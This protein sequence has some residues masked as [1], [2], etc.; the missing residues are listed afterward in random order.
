MEVEKFVEGSQLYYLYMCAPT[1]AL[2]L[3]NKAKRKHIRDEFHSIC[4]SLKSNNDV[5]WGTLDISDTILKISSWLKDAERVL[6]D[7]VDPK[8]KLELI[9]KLYATS[10]SKTSTYD[11]GIN[12]MHRECQRGVQTAFSSSTEDS[13]ENNEDSAEDGFGGKYIDTRSRAIKKISNSVETPHVVAAIQSKPDSPASSSRTFDTTSSIRDFLTEIPIDSTLSALLAMTDVADR[14]YH[15][16][17]TRF[18]KNAN[19]VHEELR[20]QELNDAI[21]SDE[22]YNRSQQDLARQLREQHLRE[23]QMEEARL[24]D[25]QAEMDACKQLDNEMAQ[26]NVNKFLE[27]KFGSHNTT[28]RRKIL[29]NYVFQEEVLPKWAITTSPKFY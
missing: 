29:Q 13:I 10:F 21:D 20:L 27:G 16:R 18:N 4:N 6:V 24:K 22:E 17:E 23:K 14:F 15:S 25:L 28:H 2:L 19:R 5:S 26:R 9:E 7:S 3:K 1:T 12:P 11:K 8:L